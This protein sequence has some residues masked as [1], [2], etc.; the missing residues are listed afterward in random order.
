MAT[1]ERI[2]TRLS[3][4]AAW[5][6]C[7]ILVYMVV[8]ILY[9]IVLRV[10]FAKSTYVLDEFIAYATAAITFLCLSYSMKEGSLIRV[11]MLLV[12]LKGRVLWAFEVFST[13]TALLITLV[14]VY[15]FWTK[16][17]WRD[18][19]QGRL[20]ESIAEVPL[21]IPESFAMI[22]LLLLC[23]QLAVMLLK[24]FTLGTV[25]VVPPKFEER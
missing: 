1:L 16:T 18:I 19:S 24:L 6:S 11:N 14:V 22:G 9:E 25:A 10:W 17:Y 3:T 2:S 7:V 20:S 13:A 15:F 23:L 12:K 5:M 8:H 4:I 21:W